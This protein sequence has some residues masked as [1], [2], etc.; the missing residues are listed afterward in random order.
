MDF[1][2]LEFEGHVIVGLDPGKFLGDV[3]HFDNVLRRVIQPR[4]PPFLLVSTE[5]VFLT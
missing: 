5:Y 1:A 3:E 2:L 4:P